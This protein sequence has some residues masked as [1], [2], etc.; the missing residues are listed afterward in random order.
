[1]LQRKGGAS[2]SEIMKA[3]KWQRHTVRG[4]MA[5][6]MRKAGYTVESPSSLKAASA[7]IASTSSIEAHPSL[8]S[9]PGT[10]VAGFSASATVGQL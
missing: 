1:M 6:A 9:P 2:I 8:P 3:M 10:A 7:A 4:F 5:G